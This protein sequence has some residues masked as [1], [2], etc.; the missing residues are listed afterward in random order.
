MGFKEYWGNQFGNPR[1]LSGRIVTFIMN[2]LNKAMYK[3]ILNTVK[4]DTCVLDIGFGN[5]YLLKKLLKRSNSRFFGIDI[6]SDMV[7]NA[8]KKNKQSI[9]NGR[10]ELLCGSVEQIEFKEKFGQIY[11]INTVYFWK[12][13]QKGLQEIFDKLEVGGEFLNVCYTK[14]FLNKLGYT[15]NYKKYLENELLDMTIKTGFRAEI[16]QIKKGKS[17]CIKAIK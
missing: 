7:K 9:K 1:G 15:K 3:A 16:I 8:S 10:L 13:L 17:F 11:T 6:S 2:R 14:K 5:G 12:D 4:N